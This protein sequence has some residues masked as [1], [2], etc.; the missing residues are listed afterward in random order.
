MD[1]IGDKPAAELTTADIVRVIDQVEDRREGA[2]IVLDQV[3]AAIS[4]TFAWAVSRSRALASARPSTRPCDPATT[5]RVAFPWSTRR[6][7][8]AP[9]AALQAV[10]AMT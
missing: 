7:R 9:G 4:A 5:S 10:W 2:G 6:A 8:L 3:K 1:I